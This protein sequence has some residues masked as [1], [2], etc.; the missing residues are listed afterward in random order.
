MGTLPLSFYQQETIEVA[1]QLLGKKIVWRPRGIGPLSLMITETE[2]YLGLEDPAAHS[3]HG[4]RVGRV[5][6]MYL[7]GG[8][9]YIYFIYGMHFCLNVVTGSANQPEAVL[10][11]AGAPLKGLSS[12][13]ARRPTA[14]FDWQIANG[15]GKLCQALGLTREQ[16]GLPLHLGSLTLATH[17]EVPN[18]EIISSHRIGVGYAGDA[19]AWPLR[20]FLA[21]QPSV[22]GS[23]KLNSFAISDTP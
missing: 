16:D 22:S 5:S 14:L 2:A 4:R 23:T 10:I 7:P 17:L 20:F 9:A 21:G 3:F 8:H 19:A 1:R 6:T 15:P 11:R 18:A 12:M 13:R